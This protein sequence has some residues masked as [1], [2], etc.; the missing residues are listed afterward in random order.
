[1]KTIVIDPGHGGYDPGAVNGSVTEKAITLRVG[2][3][4]RDLLQKAG[5]HV[6]M[7]R[8]ADLS[9][10]G[11]TVVQQDLQERCRIS[12]EAKA[13]VFLS[14]HV[15][16]GGGQGTEIYVYGDGGQIRPLAQGIVDQVGKV[17]GFH[18]QPV[19]D[20]SGLY[21]IRNTEAEAMLL[22]LGFIDSSD[23]PKMQKHLD[24]FAPL[25]VRAI[26]AF[27]GVA[28]P[29]DQPTP[30]PNHPQLDVE[31]A[32]AVVS[33]LGATYA[34]S[35]KLVGVALNYAANAVR[36]AIGDPVQTRMGV[37]TRQAAESV[38]RLLQALWS[39]SKSEAV[40]EVLHFAADAL[41]DAV[42]I[43]H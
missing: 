23:L 4:V 31:A 5:F 20:G 38:I 26:C 41:R 27:Y 14:V 8:E 24:E 34:V 1:M 21:V 12:N 16:A 2:L 33:V 6:V 22:E 9:P 19:R 18:G 37:P 25:I 36:E 40:Q 29:G 42:G 11:Y 30:V 39:M 35:G 28:F 7:T 17:M 32:R 10:G 15:N 3:Q 43:P 13:D